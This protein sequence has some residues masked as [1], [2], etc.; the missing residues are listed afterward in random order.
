MKDF[1]L[2]LF[3]FMIF[4]AMSI[5]NA[6]IYQESGDSYSC[7]V[8]M[9][10]PL[11]F[12]DTNWTTS[13][14]TGSAFASDYCYVNYTAPVGTRG[15]KWL[16]SD[17]S[18]PQ[19]YAN[20]TLPANCLSQTPIQL[21]GKSTGNV[22]PNQWAL[23]WECY[24]GAGWTSLRTRSNVNKQL[25]EEAMYWDVVKNVTSCMELN[26]SGI[27]Y[28]LNGSF[29]SDQAQCLNVTANDISLYCNG[30]SITNNGSVANSIG[31]SNVGY[32]GGIPIPINNTNI[33]NCSFI[34]FSYGIAF[35]NLTNGLFRY[36]NIIG[37]DIDTSDHSGIWLGDTKN[38][39]I[40]DNDISRNGYYGIR[41]F[42]T[43]T[44]NILIKNNDVFDN[45]R[46][47]IDFN[48]SIGSV[49]EYNN[50]YN[51][52]WSCTPA[53]SV[54]CCGVGGNNN[55]TIRHNIIHD[56]NNGDGITIFG[57]YNVI[58]NNTL[59]N[60]SDAMYF[61]WL[62]DYNI[63]TLNNIYNNSGG[64]YFTY[65]TSYNNITSNTITDNGVWGLFISGHT[66]PSQKSAN[67]L[68]RNNTVSGHPNQNIYV[69]GT[70]DTIVDNNTVSGSSSSPIIIQ[71][72]SR[73]NVTDNTI[74]DGSQSINLVFTDNSIIKNNRAYNFT[75]QGI[76]LG[77]GSI[78]NLVTFNNVS[79]PICNYAGIHVNGSSNYN[80]VSFNN[81]SASGNFGIEITSNNN[82]NITDNYVVNTLNNA[83]NTDSVDDAT[84]QNNYVEIYS[85]N[86][87]GI[88]FIGTTPQNNKAINN[89][90]YSKNTNQIGILAH[91]CEN[92]LA[93]SNK[94]YNVSGWGIAFDIETKNSNIT[95]NVIE[96]STI[97]N[98]G[99]IQSYSYGYAPVQNNL[100]HGNNISGMGAMGIHVNTA[101]GTIVQYNIIK[102]ESYGNDSHAILNTNSNNS[103]IYKNFIRNYEFGIDVRGTSD[104][105]A[106]V[107]FD[108]IIQENYVEPNYD[109]V[110]LG[111]YGIGVCCGATGTI[112][113]NNTIL[114]TG[115][116]IQAWWYNV[117]NTLIETNTIY[118]IKSNGIRISG[119]VYPN[120]TDL[121]RNVTI[122]YNL[123]YDTT[124]QTR[125]SYQ[126]FAMDVLNAEDVLISYNT[127][128][129]FSYWCPTL[130]CFD[131]G[132]HLNGSGLMRNIQFYNNVLDNVTVGI[133]LDGFSSMNDSSFYN[134]EINSLIFGI[135][136]VMDC[137]SGSCNNITIHH[138]SIYGNRNTVFASGYAST[139]SY[140][141][142]D[143]YNN[144]MYD[145]TYGM[146]IGYASLGMLPTIKTNSYNNTLWNN[147]VGIFINSGSYDNKFTQDIVANNSI[148]DI[149]VRSGTNN[150]F[151]RI[152]IGNGTIASIDSVTGNNF[153]VRA[154]QVADRPDLPP[155]QPSKRYVALGDY[156]N[157]SKTNS[158]AVV[159][160]RTY[161]DLGT[162]GIDEGSVVMWK[163]NN[164]TWTNLNGNLDMTNNYIEV[165]NITDFSIF[166]TAGQQ[167]MTEIIKEAGVNALTEMLD[168]LPIILPI[169]ILSF[170]IGA[171][172]FGRFDVDTLVTGIFIL[173]VVV[174]ALVLG[175]LILTKMGIGG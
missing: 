52:S 106:I 126:I 13:T 46:I 91:R 25:Y 130:T 172:V 164:G 67:F 107:S 54:S 156:I 45:K 147:D 56:N 4:I 38:V 143:I 49:I 153:T 66:N 71:D 85:N 58:Q 65:Q 141:P 110:G 20:L 120:S 136:T 163:Y 77:G 81:V 116:G 144:Y 175:A 76:H 37:D 5:S 16:V 79:S 142:V 101:N 92:C 131:E 24:N 10:T 69:Y 30:Y 150:T 53:P 129:N 145:N 9:N 97:S 113:R 62:S 95:Y 74:Y 28:E 161:Y 89:T 108:N 152:Q 99:G 21:R 51:N 29:T 119:D 137:T 23:G 103:F 155:A 48:S 3:I 134:N 83:I 118:D 6:W 88:V 111:E 43:A 162:T 18:A 36:N 73:I 135:G 109:N 104:P 170:I 165:T 50:V 159:S 61:F 40:T 112:I 121:L 128:I 33:V 122:R 127:I 138:N 60:N 59:Y 123:I 102:N 94:I 32:G 34:N 82:N 173:I 98:S 174:L 160:L 2:P 158:I 64:I 133:D 171:F 114:N 42:N 1:R 31:I 125:S 72:S 11:N 87:H 55:G 47:G 86:M 168:W 93:D 19:E 12:N 70:N 63:I 44:Q 124:F 35:M 148:A 80:T 27:Y 167:P 8:G 41:L 17:G 26:E 84:I 15:A 149:M 115:I 132:L 169:L 117:D 146:R 90:I 139:G 14:S 75:N 78:N 151:D 166:V 7:D 57:D 140:T 39:N 105:N 100:I 157:I 154:V 68:I 96:N 22:N